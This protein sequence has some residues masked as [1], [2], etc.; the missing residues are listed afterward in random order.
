MSEFNVSFKMNNDEFCDNAFE[1]ERILRKVIDAVNC[2]KFEGKIYDI[3]GN[4]IG[5]YWIVEENKNDRI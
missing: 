3:N 5:K 2:G 1:S 4:A